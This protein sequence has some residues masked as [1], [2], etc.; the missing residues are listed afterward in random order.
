[1]A[2]AQFGYLAGAAGS[3]I[4]VTFAAGLRVVQGAEAVGDLLDFIELGLVGGMRGVVGQAIG[5]V[6]KT[7]GSFRKRQSKQKGRKHQQ[8]QTH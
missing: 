2:D 3:G 8:G 7:G 4:L 5:F 1:M 6:V